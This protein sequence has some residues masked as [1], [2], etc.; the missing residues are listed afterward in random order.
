[1]GNSVPSRRTPR[2]AGPAPVS[3]RRSPTPGPLRVAHAAP[4]ISAR[5][6][7]PRKSSA[8]WPNIRTA[9][10]LTLSISPCSSSV[11]IPSTAVSTTA[12][13]RA[14]SS[15]SPRSAYSRRVT[16]R[17][18]TDVPISSPDASRIGDTV[19]DTGTA[20]PSLRSRTL[21]NRP[22]RSR[23][24]RWSITRVISSARS[25]GITRAIDCPTISEA[26]YPSSRSAAGFHTRTVPSSAQ[27]I[28]A[29]SA[30]VTSSD[31]SA[32]SPGAAPARPIPERSPAPDRRPGPAPPSS[33]TRER[34]APA[35]SWRLDPR[36]IIPAQAIDAKPIHPNG[37]F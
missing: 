16:S 1:M 2:I 20:A 30:D 29:S 18:R 21:S 34:T 14:S 12:R 28:T 26:A 4:G 31:S 15:R 19:I 35:S 9:A 36:S 5:T 10:A 8:G 22:T 7:R 33:A 13:S 32:E 11:R 27:P 37:R 6:L 3:P 23:R 25:G 17:A 24:R